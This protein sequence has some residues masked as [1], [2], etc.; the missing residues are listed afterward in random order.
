MPR[1]TKTRTGIIEN[2]QTR[3]QRYRLGDHILS[4]FNLACS[5]DA[6]CA[7]SFEDRRQGA[8]EREENNV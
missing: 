4:L 5:T 2:G 7:W 3:R 8:H 1:N 6:P